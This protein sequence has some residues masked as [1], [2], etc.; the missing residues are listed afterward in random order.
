MEEKK[1]FEFNLALNLDE[2]NTV[3]TALSSGQYSVVSD[4][5][6]KIRSQALGQMPQEQ[7]V[8]VADE[9]VSE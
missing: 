9:V 2:V 3:L 7:P 6:V 5:I 1:V 8:E 4:L